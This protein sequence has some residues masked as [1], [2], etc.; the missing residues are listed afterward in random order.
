MKR[1]ALK[2]LMWLQT[3]KLCSIIKCG[4]DSFPSILFAVFMNINNVVIIGTSFSTN[5]NNVLLCGII[6]T[7]TVAPLPFLFGIFLL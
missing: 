6:V 3:N 5:S 4:K 7:K 2:T 1:K